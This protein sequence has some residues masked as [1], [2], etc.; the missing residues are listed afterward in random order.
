VGLKP[1]GAL[2]GGEEWGGCSGQEA[3]TSRRLKV[4]SVAKTKDAPRKEGERLLFD[5]V[6]CSQNGGSGLLS[7]E[8]SLNIWPQR[9]RRSKYRLGLSNKNV[10]SELSYSVI[11][12]AFQILKI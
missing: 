6:L 8:K 11:V 1:V 2:R 3:R 5:S 12:K 7:S 10:P 4:G 9:E